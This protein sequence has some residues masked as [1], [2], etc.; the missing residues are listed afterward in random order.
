MTKI[1]LLLNWPYF[2][3][4]GIL[5]MLHAIFNLQN[6]I[7]IDLGFAVG[8]NDPKLDSTGSDSSCRLQEKEPPPPWGF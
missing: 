4:R 5:V 6:P 1:P 3:T 7:L 8:H 2:K